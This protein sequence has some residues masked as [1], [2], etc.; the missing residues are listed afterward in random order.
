M[1][2]Q[3]ATYGQPPPAVDP[4]GNAATRMTMVF[5]SAAAFNSIKVPFWLLAADLQAATCGQFTSYVGSGRHI[6]TATVKML[7]VLLM[8]NPGPHSLHQLVFQFPEVI[9]IHKSL[10]APSQQG[11]V[12]NHQILP[13]RCCKA[14]SSKGGFRQLE[15]EGIVRIFT[16]SWASPLHMVYKQDGS[17]QPCSHYHHLDMVMEPDV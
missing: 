10:P 11:A 15:K 8:T 1:V 17:W 9:N 6:P 12:S 4:E 7:S 14:G 5:S 2:P 16:S 13:L 3:A